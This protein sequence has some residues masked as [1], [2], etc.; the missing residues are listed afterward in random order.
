MMLNAKSV[1]YAAELI[2]FAECTGSTDRPT[3][4]HGLGAWGRWGTG[5][6]FRRDL[7]RCVEYWTKAPVKAT[8]R[9]NGGL[10]K[11]RGNLCGSSPVGV[12]RPMMYI[13]SET[14]KHVMPGPKVNLRSAKFH[15]EDAARVHLESLLW[16]HGP[17]CPRCGVFGDR[18]TK[19]QGK[20]P[21]GVY[22]CKDCRKPFSD[23]RNRHGAVAYPPVEMA[24]RRSIHGVQQKVL[25]RCN[26]NGCSIPT[27]R[28]HG[29]YS[30]GC[31]RPRTI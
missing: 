9:H 13:L 23:G 18:V 24:S 11:K 20:T 7:H 27:T 14:R 15:D 3:A 2:K 17:V 8:A 10:T 21:P 31:A 30:T 19:L 28:R 29:S 25:A 4:A 5:C 22:K 16:P 6:W 26:C 1:S 12:P